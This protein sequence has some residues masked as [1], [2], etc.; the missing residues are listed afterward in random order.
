MLSIQRCSLNNM[1]F[2]LYTMIKIFNALYLFLASAA[3]FP[4]FSILRVIPIASLSF[5]F[6]EILH[7]GIDFPSE[8][9]TKLLFSVGGTTEPQNYLWRSPSPTPLQKNRFPT[10]GCTGMC[11]GRSCLQRRKIYN[12][13]GRG[14]LS[15]KS[16]MSEDY[17]SLF[18]YI[19]AVVCDICHFSDNSIRLLWCCLLL[20]DVLI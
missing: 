10:V 11:P 8:R 9:V 1:Y 14:A 18:Q 20:S 5:S 7:C 4:I 15:Y 2:R 6:A 3:S 13:P 17:K 12:P 16:Q 19:P